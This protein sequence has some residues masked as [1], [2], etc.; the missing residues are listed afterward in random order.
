LYS[1]CRASARF[2]ECVNKE[3]LV[4]CVIYPRKAFERAQKWAISNG[5]AEVNEW[6]QDAEKGKLPPFWPNAG[7]LKIGFIHAFWHLLNKTSYKEAIK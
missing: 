6:M 3:K 7:F 1:H 5:N 4:F 2:R